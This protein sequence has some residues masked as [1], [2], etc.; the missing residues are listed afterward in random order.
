LPDD[1]PTNLFG[2]GN[3]GARIVQLLADAYA[4]SVPRP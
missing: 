2:D 1:R 4:W 3:S